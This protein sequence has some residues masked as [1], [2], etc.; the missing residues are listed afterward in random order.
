MPVASR[1]LGTAEE[2]LSFFW[3]NKRWWALPIIVV[4][5]LMG[6]VDAKIKF[7]EPY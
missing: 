1:R 7:R 6:F 5:L 3:R 2:L 4:L